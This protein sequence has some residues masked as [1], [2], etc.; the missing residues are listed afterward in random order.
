MLFRS[1]PLS[2]SREALKPVAYTADERELMATQA[3]MFIKNFYVHREL[4]ILDFGAQV[5]PV[6]RLEDMVSAST[7]FEGTV[8]NLFNG[9][10]F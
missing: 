1:R 6:P 2:E 4:K 10:S 8:I 5:D 9:L 3:L 7:L